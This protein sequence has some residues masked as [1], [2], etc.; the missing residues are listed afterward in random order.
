MEKTECTYKE[1]FDTKPFIYRYF[2]VSHMHEFK[3]YFVQSKIN[4]MEVFC[5][6]YVQN[7]SF[8]RFSEKKR[9]KEK[10]KQFWFYIYFLQFLN[11]I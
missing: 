9:K 11:Q 3:I 1:F 6:K 2:L 10:K 4:S 8:T 7:I 5:N